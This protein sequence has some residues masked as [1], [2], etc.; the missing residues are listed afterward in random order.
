VFSI[1]HPHAVM[2]IHDIND[3][4]PI[5]F[6]DVGALLWLVRGCRPSSSKIDR[7]TA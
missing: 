1:T 6:L 4:L 3:V 5:A 2:G 7:T